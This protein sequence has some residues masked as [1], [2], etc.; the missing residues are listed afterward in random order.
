MCKAI[1]MHSFVEAPLEQIGARVIL[2]ICCPVTTKHDMCNL[3]IISLLTASLFT[4]DIPDIKDA[5]L[6]WPRPGQS[7]AA[8]V[9]R[10][11]SALAVFW[12][13]PVI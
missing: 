9:V 10:L 11:A 12:H 8:F 13:R 4:A 3:L 1:T 7:S 2:D 6:M 5:R